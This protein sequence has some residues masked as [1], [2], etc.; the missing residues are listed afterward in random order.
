MK[1]DVGNAHINI[2]RK[3]ELIRLGVTLTISVFLVI[4]SIIFAWE[5]HATLAITAYAV[6]GAMFVLLMLAFFWEPDL[7]ALLPEQLSGDWEF[8]ITTFVIGVGFLASVQAL[9]YFL[10]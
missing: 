7:R 2:T 8:T 9:L 10:A 4:L 3:P 5:T 6:F 1:G